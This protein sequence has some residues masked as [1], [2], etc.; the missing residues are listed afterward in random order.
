LADAVARR[1]RRS[2]Y[3]GEGVIVGNGI[4]RVS[5]ASALVAVFVAALFVVL[6]PAAPASAHTVG[7]VGATNFHTTLSALTPAVPGVSLRVIENGSRLELRNDTGTEVVVA[8]YSGEPYARVG[9]AGVFLN[10]NSPATYLNVDRY[11]TTAVPAGVDGKSAPAWRQVSTDPVWRWHDHRVH[12]MLQS[13]PPAVAADPSSPHR[14]SD[15]TVVLDRG[16]QRLTAT[17]SL[18]WVPGPSPL[19]WLAL[20]LLAALGVAAVTYLARPHRLLAIVTM[21]LL[22]VDVVHRVGVMMVI[23]G[24]VPERLGALFGGDALLV[25]PFA[26]LGAL[27]LWHR[28]TRAAWLSAVA[29]GLT[30][31][32]LAI[33]DVPVLWRSSA[34]TVFA[35]TVERGVVSLVLGIGVGLIA[36]LPLLLTRHR[37]SAR[38]WAPGPPA[39]P[40][41]AGVALP[42]KPTRAGAVP[43][44][45]SPAAAVVPVGPADAAQVVPAGSADAAQVV[46]AGSADP[47]EVVPAGP[48]D[49][50]QL[51]P[52]ESANAAQVVPAGS[53]DPAQVVPVGPAD[54]AQ[55]VPAEAASSGPVVRGE[56]LLPTE[57]G[58]ADTDGAAKGRVGRRQVAGF[59]AAGALGALAGVGAAGLRPSTPT[60]TTVPLGTALGD[61]GARTV[62]FRGQRQAGIATPARPQA[63][64]WLAG[65]DLGPEVDSAALRN[66][67][68]RWTEAGAKLSAGQPLGE[69]DDAVIAG[70]GPAALTITVGF[71]P[72]LF[73]KAGIPLSARPAALTPLPTFAGETL[74]PSRGDGDLGVV[75]AGDD[76][77]VVTHAA[78]VLRRFAAGVAGLRWQMS[79]FNAARGA[80]SDT[81][82]P[83]NLMGQLDGTN[84]PKPEDPDFATRV[85]VGPQS[86]PLHGGSYLVVR[87]IRMLLDEWDALPVADQERVIG[88]RKDTGAPLSGGGE[89]TAANFG[90]RATNGE[91]AI[92]NSAHMRL[93]APAFNQ[94]A[95]MLRRT[96]SYVDGDEAGLLFLAWQADPAKG[97]IPVQQRLVGADAFGRFIRH[98]SSALFAMP[99]GADLDGYIGQRLLE[100]M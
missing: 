45:P 59:L 15:W 48:A 6:A 31:V 42:A 16:G 84:N 1:S 20:A 64:V 87:R 66:L 29:A 26:I 83:R 22:T 68:R 47:A 61:V 50:A 77:V 89:H 11:S 58:G 23:N 91:P 33:D 90:A 37:P 19:P 41:N 71:G 80:G 75:V 30:V 17:G 35:S 13:L 95:A 85:F 3:G 96:F 78:R 12:W 32:S 7:G 60:G 18:D 86:D 93:A 36:A 40:T 67:L 28:H 24:T 97:F 25:W 99:G 69:R 56:Q 81:A 53:A 52:A 74:D 54:G 55:V 98:E 62:P 27:V 2:W 4:R 82:T 73:G 65:F 5:R 92:P 21:S 76:A 10:D 51:V 34:P 46:P 70:L 14:I 39:K 72:S 9:P 43:R 44:E 57:P 8:G 100:A 88:R 38:P 94:G 79:G 63:R 49:A